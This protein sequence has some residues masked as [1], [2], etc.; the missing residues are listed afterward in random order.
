MATN[1]KT[2]KKTTKKPA[3]KTAKKASKKA[4][5]K[6]RGPT[7][8]IEARLAALPTETAEDNPDEPVNMLNAMADRIAALG[9][10]VLP[11][12][13]KLPGFEERWVTELPAYARTLALGEL[14]WAEGRAGSRAGIS[15]KR[16]KLAEA[17]RTNAVAS[18]RYLL[19]ADPVAQQQLDQ[20]QEG[21]GVADLVA[22]LRALSS[23][24]TTHAAAFAADPSLTPDSAAQAATFASEM[25][26]GIDPS[27]A[28]ALQ[29]R[30]NRL[31]WLTKEAVTELRAALAF[32]W[33]KQPTK[34]A[35]LGTTYVAQLKRQSRARAK[36]AAPTA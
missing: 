14:Q 19:R 15:P 30:R 17:L 5:K 13:R 24:L 18:G 10:P 35:L 11:Q 1:K 12:L 20:I 4:S 25:S 7:V 23:L 16:V 8:D 32:L 2:A 29:A 36:K 26:A 3:K 34:I 6:T 22:D 21:S 33:R 27:G 28:A 9:H 31:F